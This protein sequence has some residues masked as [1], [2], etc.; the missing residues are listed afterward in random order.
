MDSLFIR[1]VSFHCDGIDCVCVRRVDDDDD[2]DT[3]IPA[4]QPISMRNDK[5]RIPTRFEFGRPP[6]LHK[7]KSF[8]FGRMQTEAT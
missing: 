2:D 7:M 1:F 3:K 6:F 8:E 4:L 5:Q